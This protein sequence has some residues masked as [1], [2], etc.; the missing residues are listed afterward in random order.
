M[1]VAFLSGMNH[2]MYGQLMNELQNYII[3]GLDQYT[4]DQTKAYN[5]EIN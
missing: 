5:L 1:A 2:N 3:M 4:K